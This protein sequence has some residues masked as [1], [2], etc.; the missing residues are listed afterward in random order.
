MTSE[1][2]FKV[3][4]WEKGKNKIDFVDPEDLSTE[5]LEIVQ[6]SRP[7][8]GEGPSGAKIARQ[9]SAPAASGGGSASGGGGGGGYY[10]GG[11]AGQPAVSGGGQSATGGGR[12]A[13][14]IKRE[15]MGAINPPQTQV[16]MP[17]V[18][19]GGGVP[20]NA[21]YGPP[22]QSGAYPM[23]S[24]SQGAPAQNMV[25]PSY[26]WAMPPSGGGAPVTYP[27][28]SQVVT[29]A[30]FAQQGI[31]SGLYEQAGVA[32]GEVIQLQRPGESAPPA[33]PAQPAKPANPAG[34]ASNYFEQR[35]I[36]DAAA[37]PQRTSIAALNM[38]IDE[39]QKMQERQAD[40]MRMGQAVESAV[41]ESRKSPTPIEP[42]DWTPGTPAQTL[43]DV[44]RAMAERE[45]VVD[46]NL[47]PEPVIVVPQSMH[48]AAQNPVYGQQAPVHQAQPTIVLPPIQ[49]GQGQYWVNALGQ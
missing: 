18:S 7:P 3:L 8:R 11:Y 34:E 44:D 27:P 1:S 29:P 42:S 45:I 23:P 21:A 39:L 20:A 22:T 31:E 26:G 24:M 37:N 36:A 41:E 28:Y 47:Q 19:G 14:Q 30:Q 49:Q 43:A 48:Q 4:D 12:T 5:D 46:E 38:R 35:D 16:F 33:Q 40:R 15:F 2:N 6:G 9:E 17:M 10:G 32:N 25:T 13:E